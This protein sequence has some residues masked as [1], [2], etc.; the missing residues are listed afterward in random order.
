M[1]TAIHLHFPYETHPLCQ[2]AARKAQRTVQNKTP[3][4]ETVDVL[5]SKRKDHKLAY[6][7][8]SSG[9]I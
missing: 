1:A 5:N 4:G 6:A 3:Q 9:D 8:D 7:G 2:E